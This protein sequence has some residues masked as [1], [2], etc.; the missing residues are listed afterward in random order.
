ML[1][2]QLCLQ[3]RP[4]CT[5]WSVFMYVYSCACSRALTAYKA[6]SVYVCVQAV[7]AEE[8]LLYT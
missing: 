7:P 3:K 5:K 1:C 8:T 2:V 4:Y 6:V